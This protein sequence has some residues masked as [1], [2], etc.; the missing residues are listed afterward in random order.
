M[1]G[2]PSEERRRPLELEV[3]QAGRA[4][5]AIKVAPTKGGGS[6]HGNITASATADEGP[7]LP[8]RGSMTL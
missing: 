1:S 4:P 8:F 2:G 3:G 5:G 6:Q 7:S